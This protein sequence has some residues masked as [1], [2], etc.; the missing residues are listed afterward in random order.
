MTKKINPVI[1]NVQSIV[2]VTTYGFHLK[3][4]HSYILWNEAIRR[5]HLKWSDRVPFSL[6]AEREH[7]R[8]HQPALPW[9][10]GRI[11]ARRPGIFAVCSGTWLTVSWRPMSGRGW[12]VRRTLRT[13][14]SEPSRGSGQA[15]VAQAMW[16]R[17]SQFTYTTHKYIMALLLLIL[18]IHFHV[19]KK[20]DNAFKMLNIDYSF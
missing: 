4:I 19:E 6:R 11:T 15:S 14:G 8:T 3:K 16:A 12:P 17:G 2:L 7:E 18:R 1:V 20:E 5:K 10:S 9:H 13:P